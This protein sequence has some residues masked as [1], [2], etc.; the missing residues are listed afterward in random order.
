MQTKPHQHLNNISQLQLYEYQLAPLQ[1]SD[2]TTS[3]ISIKEQTPQD[4]L[5]DRT[6]EEASGSAKD[7][8]Q[9]NSSHG[10]HARG[11]MNE[12]SLIKDLGNA[13][14]EEEDSCLRKYRRDEGARA[15]HESNSGRKIVGL[16]AQEVREVLPEAVMETV[17]SQ[18]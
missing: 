18:S 7:H 3:S 9:G 16:L 2:K 12:T 14:T 15:P 8:S 4:A 1:Q 5:G 6:E 13:I 17:S 11:A 10:Y